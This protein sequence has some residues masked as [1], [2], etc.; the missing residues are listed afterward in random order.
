MPT[1]PP[2]FHP[3]RRGPRPPEPR[4]TAHRRGYTFA[5]QKASHAFL[6]E[7]PLCEECER[8]GR[9]TAATVVD[10]VKPHRG[11]QTLFWDESGWQALCKPCH[12]AKTARGE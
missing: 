10:H 11:D 7:H 9:L 5:W 12:D 1:R 4:G 8:H 2:T 6:D 3:S